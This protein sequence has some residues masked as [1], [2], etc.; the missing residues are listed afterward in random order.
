MVLPVQ[1]SDAQEIQWEK[2]SLT[3][4]EEFLLTRELFEKK[5]V[6]AYFLDAKRYILG[7]EPEKAISILNSLDTSRSPIELIRRRYLALA[8][9]ILEDHK[10]T[11]LQLDH[12]KLSSATY[13]GEICWLKISSMMA[14]KQTDSVKRYFDYCSLLNEP[15]TKNDNYWPI[16]IKRILEADPILLSGLD[17]TMQADSIKNSEEARL[18]LKIGLYTGRERNLEFLIPKIPGEVF[19][20][21]KIR[22]LIGFL[23]YRLNDYKKAVEFVEDIDSSNAHNIRGNVEFSKRAYELAYGHYRLALKYKEY[24]R[25]ALERALPLSWKLA[26][27]EDGLDLLSRLVVEEVDTRQKLALNTAFQVRLKNLKRANKQIL[28]LTNLFNGQ[29]PQTGHIMN[30]YIAGM[31]N[32]YLSAIKSQQ[33]ACENKEG[34]NC[35]LLMNSTLWEEMG[36]TVQRDEFIHPPD[37][38]WNL[39]GLKSAPQTAAEGTI[40]GLDEEIYID[41]KNIEELDHQSIKVAPVFTNNSS[42]HRP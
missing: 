32:D 38:E 36:K 3:D 41:Q 22:E 17:L 9:F 26:K 28:Q 12:P 21:H 39:E 4:I 24:S 14:L 2:L 16:N 37:E 15:Y 23:Y 27:Y 40:K 6:I 31:N 30:S 42:N 33:K 20:S 7:G 25:N 34:L 10:N 19:F 1:P 11:Q 13:F 8:Y 29:L 5:Q 18:W 35:W